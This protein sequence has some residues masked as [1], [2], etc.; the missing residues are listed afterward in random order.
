MASQYVA[1]PGVVRL[2][3][4]QFVALFLTDQTIP[5]H[6]R[7]MFFPDFSRAHACFEQLLV[8]AAHAAYSYVSLFAH[9]AARAV[10]RV[11]SNSI[12]C[13]SQQLISSPTKRSA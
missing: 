12:W 3:S 4:K 6:L 2:Q 8:P 5:I 9:Y 1:G 10:T 13:F 11:I 7:S